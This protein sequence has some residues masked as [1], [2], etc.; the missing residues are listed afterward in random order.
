M[1]LICS[2]FILTSSFVNAMNS[3]E[4]FN[5]ESYPLQKISALSPQREDS[6]LQISSSKDFEEEQSLIISSKKKSFQKDQEKLVSYISKLRQHNIEVE[7]TIIPD[8]KRVRLFFGSTSW[9]WTVFNDYTPVFN[10]FPR[11]QTLSISLAMPHQDLSPEE[12]KSA[13]N[14][15]KSNPNFVQLLFKNLEYWSPSKEK[16]YL[17]CLLRSL[18]FRNSL[19]NNIIT[20]FDYN[21]YLVNH[22]EEETLISE[23]LQNGRT[24][25]TIS[26]V[27]NGER[28][29]RILKSIEKN[30]SINSAQFSFY[31]RIL[32]PEEVDNLTYFIVNSPSLKS[33]DLTI[34][35]DAS[36]LASLA[37]T[38]KHES[39]SLEKLALRLAKNSGSEQQVM[40]EATASFFEALQVNKSLRI[41]YFGLPVSLVHTKILGDSL[42]YN[43]TLKV[44]AVPGRGIGG[45]GVTYLAERLRDNTCLKEMDIAVNGISDYGADIL[46]D[47]LNVNKT[48]TTFHLRG[49]TMSDSKKEK[50]NQV[51]RERR[52]PIP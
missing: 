17:Q 31:Y 47:L 1:S 29:K 48:L 12:L 30:Q 9:L 6:S 21:F 52:T 15:A 43:T 37:N 45:E 5:S 49:N 13:V 33:L 7:S 50:I 46:L 23:G 42:K 44:L 24:L 22:R 10:N 38:L 26:I 16:E 36:L 39:L 51:L 2:N 28:G 20:N 14:L 3:E 4:N 19:I 25:K 32:A 41:L 8:E 40:E 11:M 35:L 34:S 18:L 27:F